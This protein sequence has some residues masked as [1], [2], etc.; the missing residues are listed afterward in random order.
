MLLHAIKTAARKFL[1]AGRYHETLNLLDPATGISA[2]AEIWLLRGAA[3][4]LAGKPH[5]AR[6]CFQ[7]AINLE[8]GWAEAHFNLGNA[9]LGQGDLHA[10]ADAF[11][12]AIR[13]QPDYQQAISAFRWTDRRRWGKQRLAVEIEGGLRVVCP[14]SLQCATTYVL[15]EQEDWFELEIH[16]LRRMV[17][18]GMTVVDIGANHGVYSLTL[19]K[20]VGASGHVW[21]FEPASDP[22]DCLAESIVLNGLS[23]VTL[24]RCALSS[25]QGVGTL[26]IEDSPE[27]NRLIEAATTTTDQVETVRLT[28]LDACA[29]EF[30]WRDIDFIKLDAEGAEAD[31][32]EGGRNFLSSSSPLI[33]F[34]VQHK[35]LINLNLVDQFYALGFESYRYVPGIG[36]IIPWDKNQAS[37]SPQL[38]LF[39][40]RPD[41]ADILARRGLMI[42]SEDLQREPPL[43]DGAW[44]DFYTCLSC[45][46]E[47]QV[48]QQAT[49]SH[50]KRGNPALADYY[51]ALDAYAASCDIQRP[52]PD[53]YLAL[54][55]AFLRADSAQRTGWRPE[56][57]ALLARIGLALGRRGESLQALYSLLS[58]LRTNRPEHFVPLVPPDARFDD[59]P[60]SSYASFPDWL[61]C[62]TLETWERSRAWSSFW[63]DADEFSTLSWLNVSSQYQTTE[64]N[65]RRKL[66]AYSMG[67]MTNP[68][69]D[70]ARI[71]ATNSRNDAI[72]TDLAGK[73][74]FCG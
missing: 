35:S 49:I 61:L 32:I 53:R 22:A 39:C 28:T 8:P 21:A 12:T 15:L 48:A 3:S 36:A 57:A 37:Q 26:L 10:A 62:S 7:E 68:P 45:Y 14:R 33:M 69:A 11:A 42:R 27:L 43:T 6:R 34:E 1:S 16:F 58:F 5:E 18:P 70:P 9:L 50:M 74:H 23:N 41:R 67:G 4:G 55:Q 64:M 13:H 51:G 52:L 59:I 31:I 54:E 73:S 24:V 44:V 72:W 20:A 25:R 2:D 19:A 60:V 63:A 47:V 17:Q 46:Q 56:Y 65:R 71:D 30:G 40:A 29:T 66:L 38:N